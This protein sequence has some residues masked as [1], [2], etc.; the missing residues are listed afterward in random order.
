M[1]IYY[2]LIHFTVYARVIFFFPY[3]EEEAESEEEGEDPKL[4]SLSQAIAFQVKVKKI[5]KNK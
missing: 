2:Q 3:S 4:D 1:Y 5:W